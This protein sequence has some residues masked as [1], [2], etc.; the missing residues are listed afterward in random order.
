M[1]ALRFLLNL[2][3]AVFAIGY[4]DSLVHLMKDMGA[5]TIHAH[6]NGLM[7]LSRWNQKLVGTAREA[8]SE[9]ETKAVS[10]HQD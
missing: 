2:I 3:F 10:R 1:G 4:V 7:S 8:D 9:P 5:E 6:R